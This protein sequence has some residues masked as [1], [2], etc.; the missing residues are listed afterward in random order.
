MQFIKYA[1]KIHQAMSDAEM[2]QVKQ[3]QSGIIYKGSDFYQ[4]INV[5]IADC[6]YK[7]ACHVVCYVSEKQA[8]YLDMNTIRPEEVVD[9][10]PDYEE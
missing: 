1:D 2:E 4:E 7:F 5:L 10:M 9:L 8:C 6:L 3:M